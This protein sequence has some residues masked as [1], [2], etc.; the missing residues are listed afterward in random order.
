MGKPN[1]VTHTHTWHST[2]YCTRHHT[3]EELGET[4]S[5]ST[6]CTIP[7]I[8]PV[9]TG[10]LQ[11]AESGSTGAKGGGESRVSATGTRFLVEKEDTETS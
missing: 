10:K 4:I 8:G 1:T 2:G 7:F 11:E 9:Q 5:K 3:R 6:Y